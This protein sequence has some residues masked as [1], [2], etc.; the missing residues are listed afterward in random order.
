MSEQPTES[1]TG[2]ELSREFLEEIQTSIKSEDRE[3]LQERLEPLHPADISQVLEEL[4]AD[5]AKY[6]LAQLDHETG[7]EIISNLE[8]ETR[9][10]FLRNFSSEELAAYMYHIDS[11][12][13]ADILN[14]QP[15]Q[16]REEIIA[17]IDDPKVASDVL[18]LLRYEEDRAGGLMAKELVKANVNWSIRQCI[19]E[20]RRQAEE[21]ERLY[22][23]YVV[24]DRDKLL[25]RV[26]LKRI[27]LANDRARVADIYE[28]DVIAIESYRDA[29]EVAEIMRRYDLEAIPVINVQGKLLGRITIDDVVDVI[30]EQAEKDQQIMS[31]LTETPEDDDSVWSLS[32][33]RLPWLLIGMMGGLLGARFIGV[34]EDDLTVIP[35]MAFFIPLIT[36]TGGNVGIQSSTVVVQSLANRSALGDSFWGRMLKVLLVALVNA[37]VISMVV[38]GFVFISESIKMA[39]VVAIA[40]FSVV[41]L[42]SLMGTLTPLALDHFGINPAVASG[43]FITTAND[44]LGLAVYFSVAHLLYQL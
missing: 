32:R 8:T 36:A 15:I 42:A 7:A 23:V 16:V 14:E 12:D 40:L 39:F 24:D 28:P 3:R 26:S 34:F 6:V 27:V 25:G 20:I 41:M 19:E 37:L 10:R 21:V 4:D 29:E 1:Y 13:A 33:A 17:H 30:T 2:F 18:E 31:G 11:D 5:E 43:P 22:S 44:L 35:A 9:R 38:F